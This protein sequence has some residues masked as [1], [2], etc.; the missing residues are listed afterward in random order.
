MALFSQD[1][2]DPGVRAAALPA[3]SQWTDRMRLEAIYLSAL[4]DG[5]PGVRAAA[6][7]GV[8]GFSIAADGESWSSS[9]LALAL[10]TWPAKHKVLDKPLVR[11]L[12]PG[13]PGTEGERRVRVAA[14]S[15]ASH[16]ATISTLPE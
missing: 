8:T 1:A 13:K 16:A 12:L 3:L 14:A 6:I 9:D 15:P 10:G 5:D 7:A 4:G 2:L 11:F